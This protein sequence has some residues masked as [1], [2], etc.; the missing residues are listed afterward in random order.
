M[1]NLLCDSMHIT[2]FCDNRKALSR[3]NAIIAKDFICEV[4]NNAFAMKYDWI[5]KLLGNQYGAKAKLARHIGIGQ[6]KLSKVFS[7]ERDFTPQEILKVA[8]YFSIPLEEAIN[9]ISSKSIVIKENGDDN[10]NPNNFTQTE[11][12]LMSAIRAVIVILS[13]Y[14]VLR[15]NDLKNV[16]SY[17]QKDFR[18]RAQPGAAAV[19]D[20][21]IGFLNDSGPVETPQQ[22]HKPL[23]H[24]QD[25]SKNEKSL[26]N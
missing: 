3:E 19:M 4:R 12:G 11:I 18:M 14:D 1:N 10:S 22:A 7:G 2:V 17:Q 8:K 16:F 21:L 6:D 24:P 25:Q 5:Q 20:Q 13:N 15:Q 9:G 26:E 23:R